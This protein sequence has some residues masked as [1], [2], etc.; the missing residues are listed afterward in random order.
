[1][2]REWNPEATP[3]KGTA[4]RGA[5]DYFDYYRR[6]LRRTDLKAYRSAG[7]TPTRLFD[8]EHRA[9]TISVAPIPKFMLIVARRGAVKLRADVG[10]G[11]WAGEWHPGG[12]IAVPPASPAWYRPD[13]TCRQLIVSLPTEAVEQV[14]RAA[15][16]GVTDFGRLHAAPFRDPFVVALCRR[17]W[18][19]A[20]GGNPLGSLFADG[21]ALA[22][23]AALLR[24]SEQAAVPGVTKGALAPDGVR[25]VEALMRDRLADDL[26][27][28]DLAREV[29]LSPFHFAR[30][31]KR[32]TGVS[33]YRFLLERRIERAKDL[34]AGTRLAIVEVAAACGFDT[35][36]G[37]TSA[38]RRLTGT[39]PGR[40]REGR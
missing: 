8:V 20:A 13:R 29:G 5:G 32:T 19:E 23:A 14:L 11:K 21:A 15:G 10:A 9:G 2:I 35:Q 22:L 31:F 6:G 37:F 27:L 36:T 18:D 34:L 17:M 28:E 7:A 3:A 16:P 12:L 26:C 39:T 24:R 25:R 38:F 4:M 30:A 40:W 33:P 1:M